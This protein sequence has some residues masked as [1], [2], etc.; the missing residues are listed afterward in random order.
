M[1]RLYQAGLACFFLF[2]SCLSFA[3]KKTGLALTPPMGW[4]SWNCFKCD[5][6]EAKVKTMADSI[7]SNGMKEVGYKYI[8]IDDC[9]QTHRDESGVIVADKEKFPS[10][11]KSLADYIHSKGL[12][13]GIYSDAGRLTCQERPGSK[14]YEAIDA[15]TYADW[16]V[17]YLKLDWCHHGLQDAKTSYTRMRDALA[18]VDRDI[19][20]SVCNWGM[21]QPWKWGGE[22]AHLWR[23][24]QDIADCWDCRENIIHLGWT[25][26]LDKQVGLEDYAGPDGWN[27]PDM[28]QVGNGG[29]SNQEYIAHFSMWCM[30]SA[31]LMAG[32][33]V[34]SMSKDVKSI[35]TNERA[36]S[37]NQDPLG[38]QGY[39]VYDLHGIEVWVKP[40]VNK[41]VAMAILNRSK[42]EK[43]FVL[44][45]NLVNRHFKNVSNYEDVWSDIKGKWNTGTLYT[46]SPHGLLLYKLD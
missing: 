19:V 40:L 8:V 25:K 46:L 38:K 37:I 6:D 41:Q 12:K 28:L 32:N 3:Q 44:P 29:M 18:K 36:I 42:K 35:L 27:D 7:S 9:W 11:I 26:I 45:Q 5:I 33:D 20:F 43:T 4:N 30:L 14:N 1:K 34:R 31:P 23:T 17:D 22:T 13:F 2:V 15:Q 16:G 10:G 24:T 39:K 21:K